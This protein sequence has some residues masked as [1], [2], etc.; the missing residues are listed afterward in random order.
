MIQR[1][2]YLILLLIVTLAIGCSSSRTAFDPNKKYPLPQLQQD[3]TVFREVLEE[4]HPSLYWFTPKDSMGNYFK[5]GYNHIRDSMT[6]PEFRNIL[7]FVANKIH[8]GHTAVKYSK[9]YSH[10][11]DTV[12]L[13]IFPLSF[14]VWPDSMAVSGNLNRRD[15]ILTRGTIVTGING[16]HFRQLADTFSNYL[17]GDGFVLGG[18]YQ[19]LS[20]RGMF[21]ALYRNVLGL[22]DRFTVQYID[23]AGLEKETVIPVYDPARDTA[24][25]N[26]T[27][28]FRKPA[29]EDSRNIV[30][31]GSRNVQIDTM[32]SSA[33]MTVNTFARG[34]H[35]R[36]FFRRSFREI[37]KKHIRHLIIDVRSNGGGD[38][39]IA[40]MLTRYIANKKFKLADSL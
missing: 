22:T 17:S 32:L 33:Y 13:K 12:T 35:L 31:N 19:V 37:Q 26:F 15:S 14:K 21:G 8:C 2:P 7:S 34:N 9:K 3:Y 10:Y 27:K 5:E 1:I 30:L 24:L 28:L 20:N 25:I 16:Y 23:S 40:T 39:G 6:E 38:A 18:K 11:L 36:S 29:K 4:S